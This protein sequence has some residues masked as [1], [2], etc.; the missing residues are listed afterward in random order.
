LLILGLL[1]GALTTPF[2]AL[3]VRLLRVQVEDEGAA[4][5]TSFG[6]LVR[7]I[8]EPGWHW[9]PTRI[10]PWVGVRTMSLRRDFCHL[11]DIAV[12]DVSGTS[13]VVDVWVEYRI[14]DPVRAAFEVT[15]W[16]TALKSVVTHAVITILANREFKQILRNRTELGERL[17]TEIKSEIARWGIELELVF[18]RNVSL[19]P[20]VS[21]Q[22]LRSIAARLERE[23]AH[24]EEDGRQ[25]VA[26]L[27][28]ETSARIAAIVAEAKGQYPA[29]IG[30][31]YA[32][33][34][35]EPEV[36]QAYDELYRLSLLRPNRLVAFDGFQPGEVRA[37]EGAMIPATEGG[38][39]VEK[40]QP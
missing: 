3:L 13:V 7:T 27:E 17:Q 24:I 23:K 39:R 26:L 38:P 20:E 4:L 6:K 10:F 25:R 18:L 35:R 37:I 29:A 19:L 1:V 11:K 16:E 34:S 33:L 36:C 5:V 15:S 28:A 2:V 31:V 30:R 32:E 14:A 22:L 8:R 9:L 40:G 21:Q 12:N